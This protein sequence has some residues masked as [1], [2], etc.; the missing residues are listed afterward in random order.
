MNVTF[1]VGVSEAC[2]EVE[3]YMDEELECTERFRLKIMDTGEGI[4][5]D[6]DSAVIVVEIVDTNS[7]E[8]HEQHFSCAM[9][10]VEIYVIMYKPMAFTQ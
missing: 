10:C 1:H 3:I 8:W 5:V 9:N 7:C 6:K 2:F 4:E